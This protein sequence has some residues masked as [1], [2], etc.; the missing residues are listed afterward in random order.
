MQLISFFEKLNKV[1]LYLLLFLF[2]IFFFPFTQNTLDYPKQILLAILIPLSLIGFL[3]KQISQQ[4]FLLKGEKLFYL[5]LFLIFL[6]FSLSSIFSISPITSFFGQI[7]EISDSFVSLF[8]LLALSFLFINSFQRED[9]LDYCLFLFLISAGIVT[10]FNLFQIF[11]VFLL[12]FN[13]TKSVS[14]NTIGTP[15]GLSLFLVAILPISLVLGFKKKKYSKLILAFFSLLFFINILLINFDTA[16]LVLTILILFLFIFSFR[17]EKVSIIWSALLMI[18]LILSIFFYF[19][20]VSLLRSPLPPE[21]SL[22]LPSEVYIIKGVFSQGVKNLL[23]GTGP[24]TF[25]FDY[26]KY[27]APNLNQT[28]F[29]G[30]RFSNGYSLFLDWLLTKG[31]LGGASLLFFYIL[32]L[33]LIFK[34]LKST[35]NEDLLETRLALAAGG[36]GLIITSLIY[37]FNLSLSFTIFLLI[38]IYLS[39]LFETK[40]IA[41]STPS[42][43]IFANSIFILLIIFSLGLFFIEGCGF[44]AE[45]RY[46]KGLE[47]F[48]S[49]K[50]DESI[51]KLESAR[52]LNSFRDYFQRDLSQV[53]LAK[54]NLISQDPKL[55]NEEKRRLANVAIAKG[56]E[57]INF[58]IKIASFNV[59]NW[60]VRGL[61]YRNLIGLEGAGTISLASYQKAAELEP[62]SPFPYGEMGRVQILLAQQSKKAEEKNSHLDAALEALKRA[63]SLKPD[64]APAHYLM[65]VALDQKGESEQAILELEEAKL[66]APRDVEIA[67]QLGRLYWRKNDLE[68]AQAEFE[69]VLNLF[70]NHPNARYMLGL[71]YDKKG[72]KEKAKEEFKKLLA[73]NPQNQELNKIIENLNKGLGA[74]EGITPSEPPLQQTSS[75]IQLR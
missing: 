35:L 19:F 60:N 15:G 7:S 27:H 57:V 65:A 48:Q 3:G 61:F 37:P 8:L 34:N 16:W 44:L 32:V 59:A 42:N 18:G 26:S 70:E 58:A 38:S 5:S 51:K 64:Y 4:K 46:L 36:L 43:M 68:K 39:L 49:G 55:S 52:S 1:P 73:L 6:S 31:V 20:P 62:S 29:W 25:I 56:A 12:P 17:G 11:K 54:A 75:E 22:S 47:D 14:F 45:M 33:N 30:T 9:E 53:Y 71:V 24:S 67:F 13:I 41:I 50:I 28:I 23:L 2:P 21:L 74:L 69:R 72:E 10:L 66:R 40:E 63:I